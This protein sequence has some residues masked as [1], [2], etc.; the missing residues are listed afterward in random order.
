MVP[1]SSSPLRSQELVGSRR[2]GPCLIRG[3]LAW[4]KYP[5]RV[6]GL[7]VS[8]K[9]NRKQMVRMG[10]DCHDWRSLIFGMVQSPP[11]SPRRSKNGSIEQG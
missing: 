1:M 4:R 3:E 11:V 5:G 8:S 7:R 9:T 2:R 6:I 10:Y